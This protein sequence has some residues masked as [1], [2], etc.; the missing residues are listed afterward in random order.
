MLTALTF[1]PGRCL[2]VAGCL[3]AA[4]A[5][6]QPAAGPYP[7]KPVRIVV[8]YPPGGAVD[9]LAR[10]L[11]QPFA[12]AFGQ[13]FVIENRGGAS[14]IIGADV[15]AKSP[16]DG[17]TLILLSGTHTVNPS[18]YRK[19]PYDTERDFA[20]ISLIASSAYILVVH[21][22][23][24]VKSVRELIAF[25]RQNRGQ[26]NY[27]SSGNAGMP[28]LSGELFKV[29]SGIEMTHIPY[30]GSAAVTTAVLSGEVPIMFSNLISTMPQVQANRLR[31]LGVTGLARIAAAPGVPTI[32]ESGLPGYEVVGWY[33][34]MAPAGTPA[35]IIG[36]LSAQTARVLQL[37]EVQKRF[38]GEGIDAVGST[39]EAFAKTIR[40]DIVKWA[41]VV[42]QSG[43]KVD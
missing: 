15:T 40:D 19:L 43:A 32:A 5:G 30:K 26:V 42:R 31:A 2:V 9:A 13:Q 41:D 11:A 16:P 4:T 20:A 38:A 23:L 25:A 18:L 35:D 12:Q 1:L 27:A 10:V 29:K 37:P 39:P 24:P 36:R 33:G 17:Y 34:L 21:P 14:G 28:H 6:A 3:L 8:G 22:S 7:V